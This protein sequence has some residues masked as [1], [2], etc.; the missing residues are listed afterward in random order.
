MS[1]NLGGAQSQA[2]SGPC[3]PNFVCESRRSTEAS[4]GPCRPNFALPVRM[5]YPLEQQRMLDV[6]GQR[7]GSGQASF[8]GAI[9]HLVDHVTNV[10]GHGWRAL[11]CNTKDLSGCMVPKPNTENLWGKTLLTGSCGPSS[12][13][14][15]QM[16]LLAPNRRLD[17]RWPEY[18]RPV[19]LLYP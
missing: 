15:S 19:H 18:I 17:M 1:V 10:A 3:R 6:E 7:H 13:Q 2:S 11:K 16:A 12:W 4:S 14:A 8:E 9:P 5:S